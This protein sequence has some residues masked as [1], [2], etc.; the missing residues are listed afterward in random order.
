MCAAACASTTLAPRTRPF[1]INY[2]AIRI[3]RKFHKNNVLAFSDRLKFACSGAVSSPY[4]R[5]VTNHEAFLASSHARFSRLLIA[6]QILEI[7]PTR[8]QQTRKHF[9]IA[10]FSGNS[11]PE[12]HLA[13]HSPLITH[14]CLMSFLF[15]T[16][17]RTRKK[18]NLFTTNKKQFLFHTFERFLA[19]L[20][21]TFER[22]S[23]Y[24]FLPPTRHGRIAAL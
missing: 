1:L 4:Q 17:E 23:I 7:K 8:S 12:P 11:A 19:V 15:D 20:F 21:N 2:A 5:P 14:Q 16:N 13:H 10:T 24:P 6:T 9:L 3:A 18:A 22:P